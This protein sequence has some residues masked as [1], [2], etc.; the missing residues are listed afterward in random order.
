VTY[1]PT[2]IRRNGPS[3]PL[4][5]LATY[6]PD[7]LVG[8]V[9][10]YGCGRGE[11]AALLGATGFDPHHPRAGVRR[12]PRGT[13]DTV[14]LTYVVNVLPRREAAAALADAARYVR[15]GG[16]LAVASRPRAEVQGNAR[17]RG[18]TPATLRREC[19]AVLGSGFGDVPLPALSGGV[20]CL[21]RRR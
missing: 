15:R 14:L 4:R 10:D 9:L 13:F 1:H 12:P 16:Y 19:R 20:V 8:R 7:V 17:Q 5:H 2:A 18:H 3:A 11:D 21:W 6:A